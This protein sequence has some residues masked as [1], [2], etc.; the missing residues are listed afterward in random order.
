MK[1]GILKTVQ[2]THRK[3]GKKEIKNRINRKQTTKKQ[4]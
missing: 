3:T 4:T 2:V 1:D